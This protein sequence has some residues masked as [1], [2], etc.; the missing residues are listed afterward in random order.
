MS[1]AHQPEALLLVSNN[2]PHCHRMKTQLEEKYKQGLLKHIDIINIEQNQ[3]V[4]DKYSVR[5]VPWLKLGDFV[6]SGALT[7]SELDDWIA[8]CQQP[9]GDQTYLQNKLEQG[10]LDSV[11]D[12]ISAKPSSLSALLEVLTDDELKMNVRI[13]IGAVVEHF[14]ATPPLQQA[15]PLLRKLLSNSQ[16]KNR[17]DVCYYLALTGRD[18]VH[19]DLKLLLDDDDREVRDIAKDAL[20]EIE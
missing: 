7:S 17:A 3:A 12:Y 2:C 10:N 19:D 15:I 4:A 1:Q 9:G 8:A 16:G 20:S 13:G 18:E 14:A 6:F 11:I 5:S